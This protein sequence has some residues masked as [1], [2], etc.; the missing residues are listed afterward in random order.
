LFLLLSDFGAA[1]VLTE[2]ISDTLSLFELWWLMN[3]FLDPFANQFV[4]LRD[5]IN[6]KIFWPVFST[7]FDLLLEIL[8]KFKR[9]FIGDLYIEGVPVEVE[10]LVNNFKHVFLNS[11][12][13]SVKLVFREALILEKAA[14]LF[15]FIGNINNQ[16]VFTLSKF[17]FVREHLRTDSQNSGHNLF[18]QSPFIRVCKHTSQL[19]QG[20][21]SSQ[22]SFALFLNVYMVIQGK[23]EPKQV[24]EVEG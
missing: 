16:F 15:V 10:P 22:S 3:G 14:S 6:V 2:E 4:D 11:S 18:V 17:P 1:I 12:L 13:T 19:T 7:I 20:E 8:V 5:S 24:I 21:H 9:L 23:E